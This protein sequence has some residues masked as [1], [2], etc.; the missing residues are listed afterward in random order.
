MLLTPLYSGPEKALYQTS[1]ACDFP[2]LT[3]LSAF[4]LSFP[5]FSPFF[6]THT[7]SSFSY[8]CNQ[9]PG[10]HRGKC[11]RFAVSWV[12]CQDFESPRRHTS[13]Y[14][15]VWVFLMG[16][17]EEDRPTL[18]VDSTILWGWELRL[19]WK[20]S[21]TPGFMSCFFLT[22]GMVWLPSHTQALTAGSSLFRPFPPLWT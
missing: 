3:S 15:C 12:D 17:T 19:N 11:V 7:L 20:V 8:L 5:D 21:W 22:V 10:N 14:A 9:R 2:R 1:T 18:S 13:G 16:F 4:L 6:K